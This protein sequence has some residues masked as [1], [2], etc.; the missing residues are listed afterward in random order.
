[1]PLTTVINGGVTK[2]RPKQTSAQKARRHEK[3]VQ[4]TSK[5]SDAKENYEDM[6]RELAIKYGRLV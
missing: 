2:K 4:L 3:L 1:M 5:I 6:A